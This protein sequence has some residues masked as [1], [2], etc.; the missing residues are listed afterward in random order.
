L[1][2]GDASPEPLTVEQIEAR[3]HGRGLS[4]VRELVREWQGN[5]K[6]HREEAPFTKSI[7]ATFPQQGR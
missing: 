7:T 5:L 6:V 3:E 2:I 1:R 4:L